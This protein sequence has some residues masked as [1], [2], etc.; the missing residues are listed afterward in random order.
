MSYQCI[1]LSAHTF[2][3]IAPM[4]YA[5]V[6]V[7]SAIGL[8]T[9]TAL[10]SRVLY[11]IP[12]PLRFQVF[13]AYIGL[14]LFVS[15]IYSAFALCI[16]TLLGRHDLAQHTTSRLWWYITAPVVGIKLEVENGEELKLWGGKSPRG[17]AI[18]LSNHQSELD[19]LLA[20]AVRSLLVFLMPIV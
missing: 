10:F 3:F 19:V 4:E 16:F 7:L 8:V 15:L 18:F 12:N 14:T 2:D 17:P 5:L 1:L 6:T 11:I 13:L 20:S 9:T